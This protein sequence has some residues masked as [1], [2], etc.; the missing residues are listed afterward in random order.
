MVAGYH[1]IWT[2]Y[3]YWLPNDPRGSTSTEVR[4]E[5]IREL[6]DLHHGR[7]PVQPSSKEIHA[8]H[9]VARDI[10]K[11]PVLPLDDDEI[12]LLGQVFGEVTAEHGYICYACAIMPDHVHMLIRRHRDRAEDVIARFQ[13]ASRAALI[14][15]GKR[16]ATLPVWTA[17]PGW[18]TFV[19]TQRQ[20]RNEL[21]YIK[22]NPTKI[23][24]RSKNGI[25]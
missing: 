7:K 24:G 9:E 5:P 2:I 22:G 23:G 21:T 1:L 4:V 12:A 8:F 19:N 10:L 15:A 14:A 18:K 16:S 17:G 25:S 13:E 20:F 6:G 3:G 11:H